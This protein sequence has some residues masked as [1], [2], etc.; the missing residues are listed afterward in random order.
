[1]K[2]QFN[3]INLLLICKVENKSIVKI[4]VDLVVIKMKINLRIR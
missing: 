4:I 3:L 2:D 1:M